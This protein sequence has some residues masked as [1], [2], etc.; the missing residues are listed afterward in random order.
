MAALV[1]IPWDLR[2]WAEARLQGL[3]L[4]LLR[5]MCVER[6]LEIAEK[7]HTSTCIKLLIEWKKKPTPEPKKKPTPQK[8][9]PQKP[10]SK[11]LWDL[12]GCSLEGLPLELLR[13]M[14]F[15]RGL[16]IAE[17]AHTSTCIKLLIDWK[18]KPTP[19]PEKKPKPKKQEVSPGA[20]KCKV[21][22]EYAGDLHGHEYKEWRGFI[23]DMVR[24]N[25]RKHYQEL[26]T[27]Q[28]GKDAYFL[29]SLVQSDTEVDHIIECQ[30]LADVVFRT[31]RSK[32]SAMHAVLQNVDWRDSKLS[33][34]PEAVRSALEHAAAVHNSVDLNLVNTGHDVNQ[35]K[36]GPITSALNLLAK[37]QELERDLEAELERGLQSGV[38]PFGEA[39][40]GRIARGVTDKLREIE[41]RYTG[42]LREVSQG[43]AQGKEQHRRYDALGEEIVQLY[44]QLHITQRA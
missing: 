25:V 38:K 20:G 8:L 35:K 39:E 22:V 18:K 13:E 36:W 16:E 34:Q 43:G 41:D 28:S 29:R 12:T 2:G 21:M 37:G 27:R 24:G 10:E 7:A 32:G 3:P 11:V 15:E 44:D 9:E 1:D 40:A 42:G 33:S 19:E 14:C 30:M 17:K 26:S 6:G 4:E 23:R 5:E 31:G